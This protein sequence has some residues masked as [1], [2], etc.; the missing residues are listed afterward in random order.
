MRNSP[1][2]FPTET[3][4]PEGSMQLPTSGSKTVGQPAAAHYQLR[5][6]SDILSRIVQHNGKSESAGAT[7][8]P[9]IGFCLY[10]IIEKTKWKR[11]D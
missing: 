8:P 2:H 1:R 11:S 5:L 7:E 4:V 9:D 10:D 3:A 6:C